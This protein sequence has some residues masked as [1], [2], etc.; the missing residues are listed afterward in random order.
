VLNKKTTRLVYFIIIFFYILALTALLA[1]GF[2]L[3]FTRFKS[4]ARYVIGAAL[5]T[6]P[7]VVV[8]NSLLWLALYMLV[9]L[10]PN[11]QSVPVTSPSTILSTLGAITVV[12]AM[13]LLPIVVTALG[14]LLGAVGGAY[15][16]WRMR[17]AA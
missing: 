13:V 7:G 9:E 11:S 17:P 16:A 12:G 4:A 15:V 5:G 2:L 14:T 6:V 3:R 8:A 1:G 10:A